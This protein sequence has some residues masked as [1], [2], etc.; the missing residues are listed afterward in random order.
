MMRCIRS[1]LTSLWRPKTWLLCLLLITWLG[2]PPADGEDRSAWKEIASAM[3]ALERSVPTGENP[4]E[5]SQPPRF[6]VLAF[7]GSECP[8]AK[9]Y[10]SK[11]QALQQLYH[12]RGVGFVAVFSNLQDSES[13]I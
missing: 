10:G 1:N 2:T 12:P 11:L 3:E 13:D 7:L 9:L 6:R 8:L 4:K 5:A